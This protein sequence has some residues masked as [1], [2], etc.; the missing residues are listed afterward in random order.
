[1]ILAERICATSAA[2]ATDEAWRRRIAANLENMHSVATGAIAG[3][4]TPIATVLE[5]SA[6]HLASKAIAVDM[7]S[8]LIAEVAI[9]RGLGF[10][11]IRAVADPASRALPGAALAAA[12]ADGSIR[13]GALVFGLCR[14]PADLLSLWGLARDYRAAMAALGRA[15]AETAT[16]LRVG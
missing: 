15:A 8:H 10:M 16:A 11:A 4:D 12:G 2:Y 13:F 3:R 14:R 6:L 1:L 5:K 7:E 9:R